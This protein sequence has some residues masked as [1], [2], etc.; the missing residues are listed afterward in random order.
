MP[1]TFSDAV[2]YL[3]SFINYE[4]PLHVPYS[5][6][7]FNVEEFERFLARLDCP[8]QRLKTIIIAGTKGKGSTAAMLESIAQ[9]SGLKAGLY[10]SPHLCSIRERIRV[11]GEII[12]EEAFAS[13]VSELMPHIEAAGM[14]EDRRFRTFFEILTAMALMYFHQVR[15]DLAVLEVG[16]GGRLD[17]TNVVTPLVSVI[18]PISL[19]HTDLLGQTIPLIAREKA[20]IIKP[21]GIAVVAPQRP[22]ALAVIRDVCMA[23]GA[24]LIDVE[25]AMR[26]RPL[27]MTAEGSDF[28]VDGTVRAYPHLEIPLAGP[29][30]ILNAATAIATAEQLEAQ[31]LPIAAQGIA[32]GLQQVH[33][34]GRL[35]T[36]SRQPWIVLDG[37]HNRDS[38]RCLRET[39]T[40]CFKY[41]RLI[42]ILGISANKD[43]QG[44]V[45]E[46]TPLA[47]VT[48][49]TRATV[50]RAAPPQQ[51]ADLAA[52]S[53]A[54]IIVEEDPQ[55]ALAHAI[56]EL[57]PGDLLLVT[58]SLY[59]VGD[60]K[61][62]LPTL[63]APSATPPMT[64]VPR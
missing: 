1:L 52:K 7:T 30:Q 39:L 58:G 4:R 34:E 12:A 27:S 19:D 43:L 62:L 55:K 10:T 5:R 54:A 25:R 2:S 24:C 46:L 20:G 45:E 64:Q 18:T 17:A 9:A 15:V 38:A 37:A 53:S 36:V 42:L 21:H 47:A 32:L 61:Q 31:G 35:E 11:N 33:W 44:I 60:A 3:S 49:V 59:L 14:A 16:V 50:S 6:H 41:R 26:W 63:L 23:Q 40:S 22:E 8:H 13:L 29:H 28:G 51:V 57:L 48:I 56:A